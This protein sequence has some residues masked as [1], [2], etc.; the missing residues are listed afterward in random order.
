MKKQ[1][2]LISGTLML[3]AALLPA[4]VSAA[5][6][7]DD[8]QKPDTLWYTEHKS[9]TEYT[10]TKPEELAGLSILVN[11][12]KYTFDGKTVKLG[13]DIDLTATVDDAPVLWT[14]IGNYIRNRTEIYF[15][16]TFDGQGHTINGLSNTGFDVTD[17][18]PGK[19][20]T[21]PAEHSEVVYG[22]F[23]SIY[24]ATI[25]NVKLS[26]VNIDLAY[27][28]EQKLL[29]DSIGALVGFAYSD[30]DSAPV[31]IENCQVVSGKIQGYDAVGGIMGRFYNKSTEANTG[32][33][34]MTDCSN[35]AEIIAYRRASGVLG[36]MYYYGQL[37]NCTNSGNVTSMPCQKD[38]AV[39]KDNTTPNMNYYYAAGIACTS[40][41][42][43]LVVTNCSNTGVIT[44]EKFIGGDESKPRTDVYVSE[45]VNCTGKDY[46]TL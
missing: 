42:K 38:P 5:N 11:T 3:T 14:P 35:A 33:L 28:T 6:W 26:N 40:A 22:F 8:S 34:R 37:T 44:A 23:G 45:L 30:D 18:D 4:S 10:L 27:D 21:T 46:G 15:Q 39:G 17:L 24:G 7:T 2:L 41:N 43:N 9:A 29:G 36:Y 31:I 16:G 19:N 32:Y 20:S 13:N 1:L 25:K 12:Y